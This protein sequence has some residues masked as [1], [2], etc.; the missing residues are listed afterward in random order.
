MSF[1]G[2]EC[3]AV[4]GTAGNAHFM[5]VSKG[6]GSNQLLVKE[7]SG[8]LEISHKGILAATIAGR[9]GRSGTVQGHKG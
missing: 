4:T 7:L 9:S 2:I 8:G 3:Q 6:Q 1:K 5:G